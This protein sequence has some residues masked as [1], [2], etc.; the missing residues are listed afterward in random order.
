MT[1]AIYATFS[2]K[3]ARLPVLWTMS[4]DSFIEA[5][6]FIEEVVDYFCSLEDERVPT[7]ET[8]LG[9]IRDLRRIGD[10]SAAEIIAS[11][12]AEYYRDNAQKDEAARILNAAGLACF[13]QGSFYEGEGYYTRA[14]KLISPEDGAI[15]RPTVLNNLG[16]IYTELNRFEEAIE[17]YEQALSII[18]SINRTRFLETRDLEP[19]LVMGTIRNN[20]GWVLIRRA[21]SED[22]DE[23]LLSEA[24]KYLTL[25]LEGSLRPRTRII[26]TGNIAEA[27]LIQG[28][29]DG[30]DRVLRPLEDECVSLRLQRLLA[31]IYR[32]HAELCAARED[33]D[34]AL[35]WSR[36][37]L[38]SSLTYTNPRQE[39]RVVEVFFSML[40]RLISG[41]PDRLS[42]LESTGAAVLNELLD[43]L[44][45]KDT[46]T[47][48]DHS[49]RVATLSRRMGKELC[50]PSR[51]ST[52]WLQKVELAGLLHD[53]GKLMVPWSL[54][55]RMRPLSPRELGQ[56][57]SHCLVG[58]ELLARL[59]L[60]EL[61]VV[62]GEHHERPDGTGYPR[63]K[64]G[65][66]DIGAIVA[67]ADA[68]EAMTSPSR[69]YR[70][71]KR[72]RDAVAE[73][74][75]G[76]GRQF[77]S[78]AA[79]TLSKVIIRGGLSV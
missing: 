48:L 12:F 50:P 17:S 75:A 56:L 67:A 14:L 20:I 57:Q 45:S 53:I 77:D 34:E 71:P 33:I 60:P 79:S 21:H 11:R 61:A 69:T 24:M 62:A 73:V 52:R 40:N 27:L 8:G 51:A 43:F 15:T 59:G 76:S 66:T 1:A 54:L 32:R 65:L 78:K 55:N 72:P 47:G 7:P 5:S 4:T 39:I 16:N 23:T 6:R 30:A 19:E 38:R 10:P 68:Y 64:A 36:K 74:M 44:Q 70:K 42:A 31:E 3:L 41:M 49:R 26:A 25:A 58:E 37:A 2:R 35:S 46:Y 29:L 18:C 22:N 28:D 13:D 9:M 63:G